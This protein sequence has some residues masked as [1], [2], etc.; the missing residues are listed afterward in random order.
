MEYKKLSHCVYHCK[1]HFVLPTKY[2]KE[3]F[4]EAV[5]RHIELKLLEIKKHYPLLDF[6]KITH[7]KDHV[8]MLISIPPKVSVGSVVRIIKTNTSRGIKEVF[9]FL[10]DLY[11]GTDGIWSDG[12]FV[13]TTGINEETIKKYIEEQG[14][15]DLGHIKLTI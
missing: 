6:E 7:D 10:K 9:P 11:W 8:H 3:I 12:Y 15:E 1:Y 5:L 13:S 4:N 14:K 2:R